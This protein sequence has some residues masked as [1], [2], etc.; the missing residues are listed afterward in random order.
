MRR[1]GFPNERLAAHPVERAQLF[2]RFWQQATMKHVVDCFY[3]S[4]HIELSTLL[5]DYAV[6]KG[7]GLGLNTPVATGL[8]TESFLDLVLEG[9][10]VGLLFALPVP[11]EE[12]RELAVPLLSHL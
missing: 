3:T 12:E 6:V 4:M 5:P 9:V 10:C 2:G 1:E 11:V 7:E 8:S